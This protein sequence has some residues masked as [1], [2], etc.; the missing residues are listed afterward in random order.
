M[1]ELIK[2]NFEEFVLK[3]E[4]DANEADAQDPEEENKKEKK[5]RFDAHIYKKLSNDNGKKGDHMFFS[6]LCG[7]FDENIERVQNNFF[8]YM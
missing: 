2:K 8:K 1:G 5:E 3:T 6:L 7:V 4:N